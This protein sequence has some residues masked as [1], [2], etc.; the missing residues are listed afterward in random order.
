MGIEVRLWKKLCGQDWRKEDI[1]LPLF[2]GEVHEDIITIF[3]GS[4]TVYMNEV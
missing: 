3:F 1:E 4:K 2:H